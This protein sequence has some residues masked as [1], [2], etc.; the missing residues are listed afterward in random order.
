MTSKK[1]YNNA[2]QMSVLNIND[3]GLFLLYVYCSAQGL[4]NTGNGA[5]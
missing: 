1:Q 3:T 5:R 4:A 2:F